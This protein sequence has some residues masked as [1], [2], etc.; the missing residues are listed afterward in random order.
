MKA[1]FTLSHRRAL[2][3]VVN[4]LLIKVYGRALEMGYYHPVGQCPHTGEKSCRSKFVAR[5]L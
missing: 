3:Y 2:G 5:E 4:P 1:I